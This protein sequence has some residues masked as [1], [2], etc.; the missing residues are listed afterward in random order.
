MVRKRG[1][2]EGMLARESQ[3]LDMGKQ[4]KDEDLGW[5]EGKARGL[6]TVYKSLLI[7]RKNY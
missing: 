7:R 1:G 3:G 6:E 4:A 5:W 2:R